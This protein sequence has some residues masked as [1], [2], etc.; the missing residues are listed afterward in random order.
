M[1]N[2]HLSQELH[3]NWKTDVGSDPPPCGESDFGA[4]LAGKKKFPGSMFSPSIS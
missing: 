4:T 2:E 1:V 3:E